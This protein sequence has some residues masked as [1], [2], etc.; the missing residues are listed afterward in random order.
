MPSVDTVLYV[1]NRDI[2]EVPTQFSTIQAAI[3][4]AQPGD[5][6]HVL[7]GDYQEDLVLKEGVRL[8]GSGP[9][10]TTLRPTGPGTYTLVGANDSTIDGFTIRGS[11]GVRC[12]GASTIVSNNIILATA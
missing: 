10:V 4:A 11:Y 7:P 5:I 3:D 9:E 2:L 12:D 8:Q 1:P 6:V